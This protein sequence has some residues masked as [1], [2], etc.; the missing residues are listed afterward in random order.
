MSKR[1]LLSISLCFVFAAA[2]GDDD[3]SNDD[4]QQIFAD[5]DADQLFVLHYLV[6]SADGV[7]TSFFNA[8]SSLDADVDI[9]PAN[10]LELNEYSILETTPDLPETFFV[11]RGDAPTVEKYEIMETGVLERTGLLN[12]GDLGSTFLA[13]GL[14]AFHFESATRAFIIETVTQQVIVWNP[15]TMTITDTVPLAEGFEPP[16][17]TS[18][19]IINVR[20]DQGRFVVSASFRRPNPDGSFVPESRLAFVDIETLEVTYTET[21]QCG[22]LLYS[23]LAPDGFLYYASHPNQASVVAS[24]QGGDPTSPHCMVRIQSG[25][26]EFDDSFFLDLNGILD[27]PIA[28]VI[29]GAEDGRVFATV[30]PEDGPQF[31]PDNSFELRTTPFWEF[32]DFELGGDAAGTIRPVEGTPPTTDQVFA[33]IVPVDD[34]SGVPVDTLFLHVL[35]TDGFSGADLYNTADPDNWVRQARVPGFLYTIRRVR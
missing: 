23:F 30:F 11:A 27:R 8:V 13:G 5:P 29:P 15:T 25:S 1:A 10:A 33:S 9:D 31:T 19:F 21:T 35:P 26:T 28:G 18:T 2:C 14:T 16:D 32:Y 34:A 7:R 20:E 22:Y 24:G 17:D 4:E 12:A 6:T 3:E